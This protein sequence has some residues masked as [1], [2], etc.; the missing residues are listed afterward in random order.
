[1]ITIFSNPRPFKGIFN[2]IQRN[3][4]KSWMALEPRCQIILFEDEEGTTKK[5][6]DE[7]G[8]ECILDAK[9]NEFGSLLLDDVFNQILRRAKNEILALVAT[10]DI[11]KSDFIEAIKKVKEELKENPFYVI[12]RR[13]DVDVDTEKE[14]NFQ[15]EKW[16]KNINK[17]IKE[18]GKLHGWSATDYRVFSKNFNFNSPSL[19]VGRPG[20]DSWLVYQA[21]SKR[22]PVIDVTPLVSVVHQNHGKPHKKKNF[23]TI[24]T[25]KNIKVAGGYANM[26]TIRDADWI[27]TAEG[28][29]RPPFP[30]RIFSMLSL[31]YPWRLALSTKRKL[32]SI[33]YGYK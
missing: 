16:E 33:F 8:L 18:K 20:D 26:M 13:C 23:F 4:I 7:Y 17:I 5:V 27:L 30:R 31:F 32:H 15:D 22:I 12:G 29:K 21:R 9:R 24:E 11:L 14:I 10:D 25:K 2:V 28:L 19:I 1:M 3:S 6:A